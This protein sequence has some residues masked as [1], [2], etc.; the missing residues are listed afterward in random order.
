MWQQEQSS[1]GRNGRDSISPELAA[2]HHH[3][4]TKITFGHVERFQ[5]VTRNLLQFVLGHRLGPI[6][7]QGQSGALGFQVLAQFERWRHDL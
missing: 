3:D 6:E 5:Q 4:P 2:K 7:R 1:F